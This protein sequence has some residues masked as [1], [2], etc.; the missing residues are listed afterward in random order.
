MRH[1]CFMPPRSLCTYEYND[2]TKGAVQGQALKT[3]QLRTL[4]MTGKVAVPEKQGLYEKGY[5]VDNPNPMRAPNVDIIDARKYTESLYE[6]YENAV[7][8]YSRL[9]KKAKDIKSSAGSAPTPAT[10]APQ[11]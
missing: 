5:N 8:D 10:T 1:P 6:S 4:A 3:S 7:K 11:Q 2:T 9:V